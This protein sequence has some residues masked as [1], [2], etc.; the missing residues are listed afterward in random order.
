[1]LAQRPAEA[2]DRRCDTA[3]AQQAPQHSLDRVLYE[4][5]TCGSNRKVFQHVRY[6]FIIGLAIW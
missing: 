3:E 4:D 5:G 2:D 6:P 1:V